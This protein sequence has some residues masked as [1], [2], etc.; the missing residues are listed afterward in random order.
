MISSH[1]DADFEALKLLTR[2][3]W[4]LNFEAVASVPN[5][6]DGIERRTRRNS[7]AS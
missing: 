7:L 5:D 6:E 2:M 4:M 1:A 3:Q